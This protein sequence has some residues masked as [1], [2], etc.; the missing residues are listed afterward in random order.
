MRA[1]TE[2][3]LKAPLVST[4]PGDF[5]REYLSLMEEYTEAFTAG[6]VTGNALKSI[7]T[8]YGV[9]KK[10]GYKL[11]NESGASPQE[12]AAVVLEDMFP[13]DVIVQEQARL[14]VPRDTNADSVLYNLEAALET[15][16]LEEVDLAPLNDP[17]LPG[18]IDR[19]VDV[20]SLSDNGVWLNNDTG[21]GAVLHYNLNGEL[22]P[23]RLQDGNY[24]EVKFNALSVFSDVVTKFGRNREFGGFF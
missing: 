12:A 24:Y 4:Q 20:E 10:L 7:N 15:R 9:A 13:E 5:D 11:M 18:Y 21:N 16:M 2:T 1:V 14:I 6:D 22:L 3:E 19:A 23:V 17:N 8:N